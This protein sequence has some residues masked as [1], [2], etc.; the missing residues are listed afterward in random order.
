MVSPGHNG[1][2]VFNIRVDRHATNVA[3]DDEGWG[4]YNLKQFGWGGW[5]RTTE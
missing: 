2:I 1:D 4:I 5:I 3:R